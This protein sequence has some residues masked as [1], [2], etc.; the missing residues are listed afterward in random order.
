MNRLKRCEDCSLE[1]QMDVIL[2]LHQKVSKEVIEKIEACDPS[3]LKNKI[4]E[5]QKNSLTH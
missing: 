1:R 2:D 3:F 4:Q 5:I